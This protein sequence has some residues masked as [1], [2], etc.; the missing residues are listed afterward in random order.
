M[1]RYAEPSLRCGTEGTTR[2]CMGEPRFSVQPAPVEQRD[3]LQNLHKRFGCSIGEPVSR[4]C[5]ARTTYTEAPCIICV[6][7]GASYFCILN[8]RPDE[9]RPRMATELLRARNFASF[10]WNKDVHNSCSHIAGRLSRLSSFEHIK[11]FIIF[12]V[13]RRNNGLGVRI[14]SVI[15]YSHSK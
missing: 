7:R 12:F 4:A 14:S 2:S 9:W 15:G 13:S 8:A 1:P 3:L 11:L 10:S 5:N 6:P